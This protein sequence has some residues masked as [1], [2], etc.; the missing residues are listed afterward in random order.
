M[1]DKEYRLLQVFLSQSSGAPGPGIF[2][3]SG[4]DDQL[5]K[6]TCPGYAVRNSCKHIRH[7][8]EKIA[9]NGGAYPLELS[10]KATN[11]EAKKAMTSNEEFRKFILKYGRIEVF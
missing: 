8:Q 7:V 3:V 1:N 9:K 10:T 5:F 11:E 6:C 2:E 4:T